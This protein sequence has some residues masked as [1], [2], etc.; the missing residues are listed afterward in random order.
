M[1]AARE[2][3]RQ[4]QAIHFPSLQMGSCCA[5]YAAKEAECRTLRKELHDLRTDAQLLQNKLSLA[6]ITLGELR[7]PKHSSTDKVKNPPLAK[8][9]A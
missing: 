9:D 7:Q 8:P 3:A 2:L 6:E 4:S 5:R 1:D